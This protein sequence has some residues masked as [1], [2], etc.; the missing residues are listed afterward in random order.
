VVDPGNLTRLADPER[1]A[2]RDAMGAVVADA[3]LGIAHA[4]WSVKEWR[5]NI[6]TSWWAT[7]WGWPDAVPGV[8]RLLIPSGLTYAGQGHCVALAGLS[9]PEAGR[10]LARYLDTYLPRPDLVYDQGWAISALSI[11]DE[12]LGSS[13]AAER[14][15]MFDEWIAGRPHAPRALDEVRV[16]RAM[17]NSAASV[18]RQH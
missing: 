5:C 18:A 14:I 11:V 1:T 3:S 7:V 13:L 6:M 17:L 2:L 8:E 4:L 16:I 10:V 9:T 15:P 12:N